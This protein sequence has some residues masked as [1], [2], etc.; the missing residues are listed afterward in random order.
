MKRSMKT[1]AIVLFVCVVSALIF[2]ACQLSKMD[3]T[4]YFDYTTKEYSVEKIDDFFEE[5]L[6]DPDFVV[7][8]K[9]KDG[10]VQYTET[11][12]GSDSLT[13]DKNGSKTYAF[14]KGEYFYL[15]FVTRQAD[16]EGTREAHSYY[17]SDSTKRGYFE[18]SES[19]TMEDI[20]KNYHCSFMRRGDGVGIVKDLAEEE[21]A[22]FHCRGRIDTVSGSSTGMLEFGYTNADDTVT[23]TASSEE[24]KVKTLRVVTSDGSDLTWTFVYGN[25]T[26]ELPDT[27]A[28]DGEV[29]SGGETK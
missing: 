29:A 19:G 15:A 7:T 11:V 16:N 8:C 5:T 28:W 9:N 14:K 3:G 22:S 24:D 17:C 4:E 1:C 21:G 20:Y 10:E 12:K 6:K 26:V 18:D 25:A 13:V 23:I 2:S 27:D